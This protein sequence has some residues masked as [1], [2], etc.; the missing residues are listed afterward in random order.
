MADNGLDGA[1]R[2]GEE[3]GGSGMLTGRRAPTTGGHLDL[4]R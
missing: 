4:L 1:A 3:P 2:V